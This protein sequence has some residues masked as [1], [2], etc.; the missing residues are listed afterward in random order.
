M[1]KHILLL[2]A[3]LALP[4][5]GGLVYS[6]EKPVVA[7]V[8]AQ[9][10]A[11][12]AD[13]MERAEKAFRAVFAADERIGVVD[14][15]AFENEAGRFIREERDPSE[16]LSR[17]LRKTGAQ[18]AVIFILEAHDGR[19]TASARVLDIASSSF[20]YH[21]EET[22]ES[23]AGVAD[24]AEELARRVALHL[25]GRL[26]WI[27]G[28][29]AGDGGSAGGVRL[30]WAS[31]R[32]VDGERY[33]IYRAQR[34][35]DDF[36]RIAEIPG[37]EFIDAGALPGLQYWYRIRGSYAETLTDYSET[38]S[39]HRRAALP[40]GMDIDRVLKEKKAAPPRYVNAAEREKAARDEEIMKPLY[41]HPVKLNLILLLARSYIKRGDVLV[42]RGLEGYTA[43]TENNTLN[44]TGP[45]A[46]Y[47]MTFKSKRLFRFREKAGEELFEHLLG[48]A[49][50]YCVPSG[51]LETPQP[52][53]T[54]VFTPRLEAI[55]LSME[56]H[57]NDR[58]WRERT[59]MFDTDVKDLRE[60]I[61]QAGQGPR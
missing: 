46:S 2:S 13:T 49:L 26:D 11:V 58:N 42:L 33:V 17:L 50:F 20:E 23:S 54:V 52:D 10:K 60:K 25:S 6:A 7:I 14:A 56:Y 27:V 51:E 38:V 48:N 24:A 43:D 44:I 32:A 18:K 5:A 34:R 15:A 12:E 47:G 21:S 39:G 8:S 57:K 1:N 53:G 28:L 16:R 3:A 35:E 4:L 36:R 22:A 40:A 59:I 19:H 61:E 30:S 29:S 55:A 9:S 41:R 31:A 45:S 37:T